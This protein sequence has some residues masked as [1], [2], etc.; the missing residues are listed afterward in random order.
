MDENRYGRFRELVNEIEPSEDAKGRILENV[1]Y[2]KRKKVFKYVKYAA[3]AAAAILI[4]AAVIN[5]GFYK[6]AEEQK[7]VN[8]YA[9]EL[10]GEDWLVLP[11]GEKRQLSGSNET[12]WGYTFLLE[13]PEGQNW[14]Y[15]QSGVSIGVD[16][17][18]ISGNEIRWFVHDDSGYDF[19][20]HMESEMT[21]YLTDNEGNKTG[22]YRLILSKEEDAC[23]VK[24]VNESYEIENEEPVKRAVG[25]P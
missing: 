4:C 3:A 9:S 13:I 5:G 2:R 17:V 20:D 6:E 23:F 12:G 7:G 8:V 24:L 11:E 10:D 1:I 21:I 22:R 18:Y 25:R 19:P 14:F 15:T 16:W